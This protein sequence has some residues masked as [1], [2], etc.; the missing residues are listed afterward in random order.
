MEY[1]LSGCLLTSAG[2]VPSTPSNLVLSTQQINLVW[3]CVLKKR[4]RQFHCFNVPAS[5]LN[6]APSSN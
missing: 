3:F 6:L 2:L 5:I 4:S 1:K